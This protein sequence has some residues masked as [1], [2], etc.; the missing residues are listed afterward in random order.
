MAP[1]WPLC[2]SDRRRGQEVTSTVTCCR[3]RL[4][5]LS[6]LGRLSVRQAA[7]DFRTFSV[8]TFE[9]A[10]ALQHVTCWPLPA[11]VSCLSHIAANYLNGGQEARRWGTAH[12]SIVPYQVSAGQPNPNSGWTRG[13]RAVKRGS[14]LTD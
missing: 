12:E 8:S 14:S 3:L 9:L 13:V 1:S 11:Q 10:V 5:E 2:C 4:T 7:S 6:V